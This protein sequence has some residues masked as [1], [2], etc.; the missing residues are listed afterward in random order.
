MTMTGKWVL[1]AAAGVLASAAQAQGMDWGPIVQSEAMSSA[2]AE[3]GREG[4][5][6]GAPAAPNA[7]LLG[8]LA[9][10]F[11]AQTDPGATALRP[12]VSAAPY[13]P[14]AAVR[15]KLARIMGDAAAKQSAAQG[16]E[17]RQLV[18]SGK[19]L[20]E[21]ERIAPGIGLR[22]N[23]A[24]DAFAFYMLAQ[25][26]VANDYRADVTRAQVAGV[27]R[28]AANAYAGVADQVTTDAARQEFGEMLAIQGAILSGVHEAAVRSGDDAAAA[29]YAQLAREGG[30]K[31]FTMDPTTMALTDDGFRK[32]P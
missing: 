19:A 7:S 18:M 17:M 14:S 24:I 31:I 25:W 23:D 15:Q 3:A 6:P 27:R 10:S 26:G 12:A 30:R 1:A 11:A 22:A 4:A 2:I 20:T 5:E 8:D 29:R 28:Q 32:K 21:Y 16:E 13:K 9:Q